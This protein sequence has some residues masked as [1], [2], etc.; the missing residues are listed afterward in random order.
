MDQAHNPP[1]R[2][3]T[4]NQ[5]DIELAKRVVNAV[6]ETIREESEHGVPGGIIYAALM[7]KGASFEGYTSIMW[8]LQKSGLVVKHGGLFFPTKLTG[9]FT[10]S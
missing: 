3:N 4:F 6:L 7:A 5:S 1:E 10:L 9:P 2:R 8:S